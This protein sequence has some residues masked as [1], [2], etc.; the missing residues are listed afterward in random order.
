MIQGF[1]SGLIGNRELIYETDLPSFQRDFAAL[2]TLDH[3]TGPAID[4]TR[5]SGATYFDVNGVLQTAAN[6]A[7]RFDHDPANGNSR[8][9][10]IEEARTNSL[11]NSQAGGAATGTP[12]TLPTN[13]G[14][15]DTPDSGITRE[16]VAVGTANGMSYVDFRFSGTATV[17]AAF[18]TRSETLTQVVASAGQTWTASAYASLAGGSTAGLS[19]ITVSLSER[20]SDGTFIASTV[21]GSVAEGL[22]SSLAI[23]SVTRTLG[24]SAARVS[25]AITV[26]IPSGAAI[27]ITLRIAAPQLELGA[28]ATSYIPTTT[29][30]ATRAADSAVVTPISSFYNQLE[31]TL[32]AENTFSAMGSS[33][34]VAAFDNNTGIGGGSGD[35]MK[36]WKWANDDNLYAF[37]TDS[38]N[39]VAHA[40]TT[41]PV[42]TSTVCKY[43]LAMAV[44]NF[45]ASFFGSAAATDTDCAM[46]TVSH[47]RIGQSVFIGTRFLNGHIRKI[48]YWPKRLTNTL[49][50]QITT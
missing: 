35:E 48:A 18:G 26:N 12:G 30:A 11:R 39:L 13:W 34:F 46:P 15:A 47:L 49:L 44:N 36:L 9:L 10:L 50:E 2:K 1:S 16:I 21:S 37:I 40:G 22:S 7:P 24:A 32:F 20:Q 6:D 4:F 38:D 14:T 27:D 17:A 29:A 5:A 33:S 28:F 31:G 45:A 23:Y 42:T 8:G 43:G 25:Q 19:S 41:T 3:G